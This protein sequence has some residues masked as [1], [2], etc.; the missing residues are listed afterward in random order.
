MIK[1][2]H[3]ISKDRNILMFLIF[4]VDDMYGRQFDILCEK[5]KNINLRLVM[6]TK[7]V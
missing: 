4:F 3:V 6:S 7:L 2:F 1:I 5:K